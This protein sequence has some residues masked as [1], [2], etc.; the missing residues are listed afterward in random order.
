[1]LALLKDRGAAGVN[2]EVLDDREIGGLRA[3]G[4]M[5]LID[6]NVAVL[7]SLSLSPPSLDN[8]REVAVIVRQPEVVGRLAKFFEER[9]G[10]RE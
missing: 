9:K 10:E 5:M 7:G 2:V 8:R 3:H 1:M 6:D 4:K